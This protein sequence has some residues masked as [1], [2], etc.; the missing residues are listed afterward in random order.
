MGSECTEETWDAIALPG[1]LPGAE[2]LANCEPLVA[3]LKKQSEA[4]KVVAA[5]CASPAVVFAKHGLLPDSDV[6]CY[7]V[8]KFKDVVPGWKDAQAIANGHVI[9]SQDPGTS[10]QY[11]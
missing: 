1:G 8:P 4:K 11:A 6:T 9:T 2:H 10:L 3:L 5:M 7:P